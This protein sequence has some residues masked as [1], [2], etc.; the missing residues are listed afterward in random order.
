[1]AQLL[2]RG[3]RD[4]IVARLKEEANRNGRSVEAEHRAMLEERFGGP[5]STA[6]M[7]RRLQE[8]PLSDVP[9]EIWD[10]ILDRKDMGRSFDW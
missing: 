3:L 1:M 6:E 4:E 5:T 2:V 8:S 10:E 9:D 7:I